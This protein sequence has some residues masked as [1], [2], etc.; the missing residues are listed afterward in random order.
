MPYY[1]FSRAQEIVS[2]ENHI[3]DFLDWTVDAHEE[4]RNTE[5]RN[6]NFYKRSV[7]VW[8]NF[9][10][11]QNATVSNIMFETQA[12][13]AQY[14]RLNSV[15]S[16]QN[17]K[18]YAAATATHLAGF[19]YLSFFFRYRRLSAG[20]VLAIASA[21]YVAFDNINNILYKMFVDK[22]I[23]SEARKM[24]LGAYCQPCGTRKNRGFNYI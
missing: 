16:Q 7:Y 19:M 23:L 9:M 24:G 18:F 12:T 17:Y 13:R 20:P 3:I 8:N 2:F 1:F 6:R 15:I 5:D 11:F 10:R 22:H 21:Y 4:T 14:A